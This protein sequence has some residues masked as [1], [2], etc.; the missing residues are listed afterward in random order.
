MTTRDSGIGFLNVAA[1]RVAWRD[2]ITAL[3]CHSANGL[4]LA[5]VALYS[6]VDRAL[7]SYVGIVLF[8][9]LLTS[10]LVLDRREAGA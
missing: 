9:F 1:A 8:V 10:A 2:R 6:A 3:L 7:P 5:F 4:G